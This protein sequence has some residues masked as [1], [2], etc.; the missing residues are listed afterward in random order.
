MGRREQLLA[1][2]DRWRTP[3]GRAVA[4]PIREALLR[5]ETPTSSPFGTIGGRLDLR[6][7]AIGMTSPA[8]F[9]TMI[10]HTVERR[11]AIWSRL[12]LTG[13][14]LCEINW[15]GLAV[16]DCVLD[17]VDLQHLRCW[18]I[19][20]TGCSL[21][22]AN[23]HFAQMGRPGVWRDVD[24]SQADL[25]GALATVR[26]ERV[27]FSNTKFRTTEFGFSDLIDCRFAGIVFGL[28]LGE[29][30]RNR[31]ANWRLERVDL[32]NARPRRLELTN[33]DLGGGADLRLP[34]DADHWLVTDWPEYI[35]RVGK[36]ADDLPDNDLRLVAKIWVDFEKSALGPAQVSGFVAVWDLLDL[37]GSELRDFLDSLRTA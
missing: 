22:R 21:R 32:R 4:T 16:R 37:G 31:P 14:D 34:E 20:V 10:R 36:A 6:G 28:H 35:D 11:D 13:A 24:L 29:Q 19:E 18:D 23:L 7:L 3:E 9:P 12:D 8:G 17:D 5:G 2:R 27:D 26:F 15:K 33:V 25:R 1:L 30:I